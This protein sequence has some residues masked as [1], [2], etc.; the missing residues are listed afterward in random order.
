MAD[1]TPASGETREGAGP[2]SLPPDAYRSRLDWIRAELLPHVRRRE[3]L[4]DGLALEFDAPLRGQ[5]D[6]FVA[7]E[8]ACCSSLDWRVLD[9]AGGGV[10]LEVRGIPP[11]AVE[12]LLATRGT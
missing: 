1:P 7:L 11:G 4:P 9:A 12:S 8:R 5:L 10:R 6:A 2:C 3:A